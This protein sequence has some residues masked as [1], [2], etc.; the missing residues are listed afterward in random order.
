MSERA[1]SI[2]KGYRYGF[3]G[4]ETDPESS[5]QDYGMRIYNPS[6]G[7]FLS[8]DPLTKDFPWHTPYLFAG[9]KPILSIDI[10]GLEELDYKFIFMKT[11]KGENKISKIEKTV[12]NQNSELKVNVSMS[13]N[14]NAYK[15]N[16]LRTLQ[17]RDDKNNN[18]N[19]FSGV[20]TLSKADLAKLVAHG[21]AFI[22]SKPYYGDV[23]LAAKSNS[24]SGEL[25]Y[26]HTLYEI[27]GIDKSQL[28][29]IDGVTYNAN[30][31]GGYVWGLVLTYNGSFIDPSDAGQAATKVAYGRDDEPN[32]Q[33]AINAGEEMGR[34][35]D[36]EFDKM[37]EDALP[38]ARADIKEKENKTE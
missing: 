10:D 31:V 12:I 3:N 26:K 13:F 23:E 4:K 35:V 22:Q 17:G 25:D 7:R 33:K 30:E 27:L 20:T 8:V 34:K 36:K 37:V 11:L 14:G 16:S 9:N 24:F 21:T 32:E 1:Y 29:E 18:Y 5:T 38:D 15:L 6:L 19:D 2:A 28:I